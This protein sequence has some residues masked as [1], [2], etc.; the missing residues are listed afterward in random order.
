MKR[1][2]IYCMFFLL[3]TLSFTACENLTGCKVCRQVTY[4][5]EQIEQEGTETE[6]C[7]A[8]LIAIEAASDIVTGNTRVA[9]ECR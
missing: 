5:N 3:M 7:G 9:W 1:K 4:V 8:E 2:L 6:Y